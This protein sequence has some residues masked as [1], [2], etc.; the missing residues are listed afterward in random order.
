MLPSIYLQALYHYVY[1]SPLAQKHIALYATLSPD[2][3]IFQLLLAQKGS[4][5][6]EDML[7]KGNS[8]L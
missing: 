1:L 8:L 5:G 7:S 4:E 2:Q 6:V 3:H